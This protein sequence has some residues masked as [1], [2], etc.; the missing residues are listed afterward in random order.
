MPSLSNFL[1]QD[2]RHCDD[3]LALSETLLSSGDIGRA[4]EALDN[5]VAAMN[6]HFEAEETRLFPAFENKTGMTSGPTQVM[7]HEHQ[8]MRALM[9][10][11]VDAL[12]AD[13]IDEYQGQVETLLIMM[14][15]HNLKEEN[16]LYPMCDR[17][18]SE[19]LPDLL[20]TLKSLLER[21]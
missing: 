8:Q 15:Q 5:F 2:H 3:L 17:H 21:A 14:Q 10:A 20:H 1:T 7:R 19:D 11:A 9:A 16:I 18:L 6:L 12:K 13:E 4:H